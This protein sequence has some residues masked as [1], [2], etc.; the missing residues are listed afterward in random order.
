MKHCFS[1]GLF[2]DMIS[3]VKMANQTEAFFAPKLEYRAIN[4]CVLKGT[5]Y[6]RKRYTNL[7]IVCKF[8]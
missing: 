6:K 1:A 2:I 5:Q 8:D 7:R 3:D 4:L